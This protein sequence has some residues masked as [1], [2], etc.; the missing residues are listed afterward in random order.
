MENLLRY[1]PP[2]NCSPPNGSYGCT[3]VFFSARD[4]T[5]PALQAYWQPIHY[6]RIYHHDVGVVSISK[7]QNRCLPNG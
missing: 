1:R 5:A 7:G 6:R 4:D 2:Q 3:L